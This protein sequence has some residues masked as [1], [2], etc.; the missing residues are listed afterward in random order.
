MSNTRY[1]INDKDISNFNFEL[2]YINKSKFENDWHST[3]HFHP[4]MEIFF[5]TNGKGKS[6]GFNYNQS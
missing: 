5:I 6:M 2:L 4:F 3:A 1:L